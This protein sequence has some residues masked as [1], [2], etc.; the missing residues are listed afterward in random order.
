MASAACMNKAGVPVELKVAAIFWAIRALFP[1]PV[2]TTL[3]RVSK[4][5]LTQVIKSWFTP[6]DRDATASLSMRMVRSAVSVMIFSELPNFF[7]IFGGFLKK[8][9]TESF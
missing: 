8:G 3:P 1:M 5:L 2:S 4:I 9:L 7:C 6:S